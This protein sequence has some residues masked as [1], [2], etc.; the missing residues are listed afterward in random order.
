MSRNM[1]KNVTRRKAL[2]GLLAVALS[3][4]PLKA[5]AGRLVVDLDQWSGVEVM[6]GKDVVFISSK[7]LFEALQEGA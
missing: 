1:D 5:R 3:W 2:C 7:E 6:R 4:R